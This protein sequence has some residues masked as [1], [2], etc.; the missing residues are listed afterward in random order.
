MRGIK[1]F[2]GIAA[3]V[4][5]LAGC[6]FTSPN[7]THVIY[8]PKGAATVLCITPSGC[9]GPD[10]VHYAWHDQVPTVAPAPPPAPPKF[11]L[12]AGVWH[13]FGN[14][15]GSYECHFYRVTAVR[16]GPR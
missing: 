14:A 8:N 10:G 15:P 6:A 11:K 16:R 9:I 2:V 3:F 12:A 7:G 13:T 4:A 1:Y 5:L